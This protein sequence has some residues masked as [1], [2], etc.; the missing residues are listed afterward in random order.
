MD[1]KPAATSRVSA[2]VCGKCGGQLHMGSVSGGP[3]TLVCANGH[4]AEGSTPVKRNRD[5]E[6]EEGSDLERTF[7][8]SWKAL[9]PNMPDY[10]REFVFHETRGWRIDFAWPDYKV[11]VEVEGFGHG[12]ESRYH[13]D[14]EKY[15]ML[16]AMGWKL[17]RCTRQILSNNPAAFVKM[18]QESL[19]VGK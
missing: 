13:G 6:H 19:E 5:V 17:F 18:V 9:A 12:K 15:N 7:V 11:A 4:P 3:R 14:V 8:T 1:T 2:K 16:M 10:T